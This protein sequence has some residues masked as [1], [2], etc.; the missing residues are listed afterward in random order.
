MCKLVQDRRRVV[1]PIFQARSSYE[2]TR[3]N[4]NSWRIGEPARSRVVRQCAD[5]TARPIR[6]RGRLR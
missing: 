5:V 4:K 2:K 1:N 6:S 3:I